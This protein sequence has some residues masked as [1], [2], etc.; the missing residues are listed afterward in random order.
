MELLINGER[1]VI[2]NTSL[3]SGSQILFFNSCVHNCSS[4]NGMKFSVMAKIPYMNKLLPF[5]MRRLWM[6]NQ[7]MH[8]ELQLT[9]LRFFFMFLMFERKLLLLQDI[10]D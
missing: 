4:S 9:I 10:T 8:F 3:N 1:F 6:S 5:S 7:C 2:G